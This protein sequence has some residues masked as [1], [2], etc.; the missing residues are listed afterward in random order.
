MGHPGAV[1]ED[2]PC[3]DR[4]VNGAETQKKVITHTMTE[5]YRGTERS[6]PP[7]LIGPRCVASVFL[8]GVLC[9]SIMDTGHKLQ[10][11]P[12][13]FIRTIYLTYLY[14]QFMLFLKSR[15]LVDSRS[16][17]LAT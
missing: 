16:P 10:Q 17:T 1:V 12:S 6:L 2:N 5:T 9:E 3:P 14:I 8:E 15:E 7:G 13:V 4:S 11:C